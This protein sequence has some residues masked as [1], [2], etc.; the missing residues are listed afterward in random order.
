MKLT[1]QLIKRFDNPEIEVKIMNGYF[2]SASARVKYANGYEYI[3]R[4]DHTP[5]ELKKFG[6][7]NREVFV[8]PEST[9]SGTVNSFPDELKFVS[10]N[11]RE[12]VKYTEDEIKFYTH[13]MN[14]VVVEFNKSFYGAP[15]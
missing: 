2:K 7:F 8:Y 15:S 5:D 6:E 14:N 4:V 13:R 9:N 1:K 3:V 10:D 12:M 11:L